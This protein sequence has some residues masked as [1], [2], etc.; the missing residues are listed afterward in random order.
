M[1]E[2]RADDAII[3]GFEASLAAIAALD[4]VR[5]GEGRITDFTVLAINPSAERL[6]GRPAGEVVGRSVRGVPVF[7]GLADPVEDFLLVA[8]TGTPLVEEFRIE[9]D[10]GPP[11]WVHRYVSRTRAGL[12]A[13]ARNVS[14][15]ANLRRTGVQYFEQSD[16]L[17]CV[18]DANRNFVRVNSAFERVLGW[19]EEALIGVYARSLVHPDDVPKLVLQEE[20]TR[21]GLPFRNVEVRMRHAD[22]SYRTIVWSM[23]TVRGE[24][25]SIGVGRDVTEQRR[26]EDISR[27]RGAL[28]EAILGSTSNVAFVKDREGRYLLHLGNDV[29]HGLSSDEIIGRTDAEIAPDYA[30]LRRQSDLRV[31]R[32]GS[33]E[34]YEYDHVVA[35]ERRTLSVTKAPY[36][37][38]NGVII[39]V[40][41]TTRDLTEIRRL[42]A[43]VHQAQKMEAVGRLAGG[44][45][46]D[47]NNLLTAILSFATLA[48]ETLPADH[49]ALADLAAIRRA[50]EGAAVL[51]RQ[52]LTFSRRQLVERRPLLIN[53]VVRNTERL[54]RSLVGEA[55]FIVTTLDPG[56]VLIESDPSQIEQVL[57]NLVVNA[58]HAMP[59][60]GTIWVETANVQVMRADAER[61]PGLPVGAYVR[62]TV[63]DTGIGMD[64][65]TQ[66]RAFEPFFT[67]KPEEKGTGLGLSSVHGIV[68]Q[69]KGGVFVESRPGAG[70]EFAVYLPAVTAGAP[71]PYPAAA[72]VR[73]TMPRGSETV[74]LVEDNAIVRQAE[75]RML[76]EGGTACM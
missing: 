48:G 20:R 13:V 16:D 12:V 73:V 41:G 58:G 23:V 32:T 2:A 19:T 76:T 22:G 36:R 47:F 65:A 9:R 61:L 67:T 6:I 63:R 38:G 64:E 3:A 18:I 54:L 42:E 15:D 1:S 21:K 51:T 49:P 46:H 60:G 45:A 50:G 59:D 8:E 17:W 71:T 25:H 30:E 35:G 10:S 4:I 74:L 69:S 55:V 39:G 43:Q 66:L 56:L 40:V 68:R 75:E 37:D 70:S 31:M 26:A 28:L 62:L 34:T 5:D 29:V 72:P 53:D 52:M 33:M 57:V 44:I 14:D 27:K 11:C 7:A 24:T